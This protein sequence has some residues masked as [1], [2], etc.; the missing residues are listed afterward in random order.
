LGGTLD[1]ARFRKHVYAVLGDV[2]IADVSQRHVRDYVRGLVAAKTLAPRTIHHVVNLMKTMFNDARVDLLVE[3]NPCLLKRGEM[4]K[5]VDKD[6]TG[7]GT[8]G[9][10]GRRWSASAPAMRS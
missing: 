9:S 5:K 2:P 8:H 1:G 7:V 10:S 4:P 3:I 6:A